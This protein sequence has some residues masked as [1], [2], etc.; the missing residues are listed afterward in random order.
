MPHWKKPNL[1]KWERGE[2]KGRHHY[3]RGEEEE[4]GGAPIREERR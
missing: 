2:G 3:K 1:V 4:R